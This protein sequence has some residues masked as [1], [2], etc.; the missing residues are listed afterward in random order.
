MEGLLI[1]ILI[2]V[3]L[4]YLGKWYIRR[5]IRKFF[6]QFNQQQGAGTYSQRKSHNSGSDTT[7]QPPEQSN[8]KKVFADDEGKYV[9]FEDIKD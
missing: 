6:G 1:F 2:I 3:A 4:Y 5:K 8:K 9:D 7:T